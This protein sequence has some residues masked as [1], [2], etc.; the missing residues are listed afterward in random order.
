M[1]SVG[2]ERRVEP[3]LAHEVPALPL[4]IL[5]CALAMIAEGFDAYSI[6]FAAP[7]ITRAREI[8][9]EPTLSGSSPPA[10]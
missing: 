5:L 4:A 6:G 3:A 7:I 8:A 2:I 9:L 10:S 1:A